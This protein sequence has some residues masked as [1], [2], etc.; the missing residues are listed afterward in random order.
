MG[1]ILNS[2]NPKIDIGGFVKKYGI[3]GIVCVILIIDV[4]VP[5]SV[6]LSINLPRH[7]LIIYVIDP[8]LILSKLYKHMRLS[9]NSIYA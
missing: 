4:P 6:R 1:N 3:H 2:L 7:L 9:I 8:H 5:L